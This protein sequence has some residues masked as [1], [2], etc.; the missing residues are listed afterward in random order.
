MR[1][2]AI[3]P[4]Y[5]WCPY[6]KDCVRIGNETCPMVPDYWRSRQT[7][8]TYQTPKKKVDANGCILTD[9]ERW[10]ESLSRCTKTWE[11]RCTPLPARG[12][13]DYS[14]IDG[15]DV[16]DCTSTPQGNRNCWYRFS[17]RCY[18]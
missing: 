4:G 14:F 1:T 9:G 12:D 18:R 16:I 15:R 3:S 8:R 17:N 7:Y 6:W 2:A 13:T 11:E 5:Q 10:C